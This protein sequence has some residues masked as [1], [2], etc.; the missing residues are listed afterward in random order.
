MQ[1]SLILNLKDFLKHLFD[2]V[3]KTRSKSFVLTHRLVQSDKKK[4]ASH[5]FQITCITLHHAILRTHTHSPGPRNW[6]PRALT[7]AQ[8]LAESCWGFWCC[9]MSSVTVRSPNERPARTA[10]TRP[11]SSTSWQFTKVTSFLCMGRLSTLGL[12]VA[13]PAGGENSAVKRCICGAPLQ[14]ERLH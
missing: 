12:R 10:R 6:H 7:A 5:V 13:T 3:Y 4:N 2:E 1:L 8:R 9:R 11:S 14:C